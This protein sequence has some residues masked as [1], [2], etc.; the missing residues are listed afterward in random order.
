M[1]QLAF[2]SG[3]PG[4]REYDLEASAA[5]AG[6]PGKLREMVTVGNVT[7]SDRRTLGNVGRATLVGVR[8]FGRGLGLRD[9]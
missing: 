1:L 9:R 4:A 3:R 2:R 5:I 7:A 8:L 6:G